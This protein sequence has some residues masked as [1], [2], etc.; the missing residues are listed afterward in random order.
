MDMNLPPSSTPNRQ[1]RQ[2]SGGPLFLRQ[3]F[4]NV[5]ASIDK[6][7]SKIALEVTAERVAAV[8]PSGVPRA[9]HRLEKPKQQLSPEVLMLRLRLLMGKLT[10][11]MGALA[12]LSINKQLE[13]KEEKAKQLLEKVEDLGR[14][15]VAALA[16]WVDKLPGW[17]AGI[18][19]AVATCIVAAIAIA[20]VVATGG[21]AAPLVAA[22][23]L[24]SIA[25]LYSVVQAFGTIGWQYEHRG[26]ENQ[27]NNSFDF[28]LMAKQLGM[29]EGS[30]ETL[31]GLVGMNPA[32]LIAGITKW[33]GTDDAKKLMIVQAV[34]MAVTVACMLYVMWRCAPEIAKAAGKVHDYGKVMA[35]A[36]EGVKGAA[37]AGQ[38]AVTQKT[39]EAQSDSQEAQGAQESAQLALQVAMDIL[40][41][42][43]EFS[44]R[45]VEPDQSVN[46]S[47]LRALRS[48]SNSNSNMLAPPVA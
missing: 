40:K 9:A 29:D 25:A 41:Q 38:A 32:D 21:A 46:E 39:S 19:T 15:L 17:L 31:N 3:A 36:A 24:L 43:M 48:I 30:G 35:T 8:L 11:T 1:P 42:L 14:K 18:A 10:E 22:A 37:M 12:D 20:A 2:N 33:A 45:L 47:V 7:V 5:Q 28:V 6:A 34:C 27:Q 44:T 16:S 4:A 26:D 23:V 13:V